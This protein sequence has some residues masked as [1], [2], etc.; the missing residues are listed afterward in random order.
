MDK[1]ASGDCAT[2]FKNV[3]YFAAFAHALQVSDQVT[4][5]FDAWEWVTRHARMNMDAPPEASFDRRGVI[6]GIASAFDRA[7]SAMGRAK[8]A[9]RWPLYLRTEFIARLQELSA[10]SV[11]DFG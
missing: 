10:R 1:C 2:L 8:Y 5:E 11:A 4:S 3:A 7:R 6:G 9:L